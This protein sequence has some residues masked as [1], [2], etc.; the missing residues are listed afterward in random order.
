MPEISGVP[1]HT[2]G[3]TEKDLEKDYVFYDRHGDRFH[4]LNGTAREIYLLCDGTRT[5]GAV[6]REI[7]ERYEVDEETAMKDTC[8]TIDRLVNLG[9]LA[10]P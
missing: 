6:A 8:E 4:I 3:F 5:P 1:R 9:L 10:C 2:G 7:A